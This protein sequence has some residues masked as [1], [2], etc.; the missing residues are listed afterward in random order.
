MSIPF[1][2]SLE[3]KFECTNVSLYSVEN[4]YLGEKQYRRTLLR[5]FDPRFYSGGKPDILGF[6]EI[7]LTRST[8]CQLFYTVNMH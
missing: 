4:K 1:N 7:G 8:F 3:S 6:S 5:S 2:Q